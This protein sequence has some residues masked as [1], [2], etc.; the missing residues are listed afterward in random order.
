MTAGEWSKAIE[1]LPFFLEVLFE[2]MIMTIIVTAGGFVVSIVLG[3]FFTTLRVTTKSILTHTLVTIYVEVFRAVPILTQLFVI[4]FGLPTVGITL[5][6]LT[7]AIIGFGLNG[8]AQLTEVFRSS[9]GSID[10]GQA[11]AAMA[12]GMPRLMG[13]RIILFPQAIKTTLP[14]LTNFAIGLLKDTSLASAVAAP[15][16]AFHANMLVSK[17]FQSTEIYILVALYYLVVSLPLSALANRLERRARQG[18]RS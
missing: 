17:T 2:G 8:G 15:E 13:L 9:I 16:L 4:Y 6:P 3:L 11:E 14:S 10:R 5:D 7:A 1:L 18:S 12:V